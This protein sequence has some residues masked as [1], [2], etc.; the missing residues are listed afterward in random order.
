MGVRIDIISANGSKLQGIM[1]DRGLTMS[2]VSRMSGVSVPV[3]K[4]LRDGLTLR[5]E[6]FFAVVNCLEVK[7]E[8]IVP[9]WDKTKKDG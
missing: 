6:K 7:P 5:R 2:S 3:V 9:D 8:E 4:K 1:D